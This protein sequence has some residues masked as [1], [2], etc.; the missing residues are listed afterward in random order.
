MRE[1]RR[2]KDERQVTSG[3]C[4]R[5]TSSRHQVTGSEP[6]ARGRAEYASGLLSRFPISIPKWMMMMIMNAWVEWRV[7]YVSSLL[8]EALHEVVLLMTETGHHRS[9]S[10]KLNY[11]K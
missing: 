5:V 1:E 11:N 8:K 3:R 6:G 9:K 2:D 7:I 4:W 10:F